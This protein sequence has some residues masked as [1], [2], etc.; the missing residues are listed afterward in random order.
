VPVFVVGVLAACGGTSAPSGAG[1]PIRV[2]GGQFFEGALPTGSAGPAIT[3]LN[4]QN[5]AVPQGEEEKKLGGDAK[6]GAYSV[7]V[8]FEDLGTGYWVVPVGPEDPQTDGDLT[9]DTSSDFARDIQLGKHT[10]G[11]VAADQD[12]NWGPIF[13][14][15]IVITPSVPDGKVVLSLTWDADVD[16]DLHLIAPDGKELDPKHVTTS[17]DPDAGLDPTSGGA[18][19]G[20]LDRDSNGACSIDGRRQEDIVFATAPAPGHY[21]VRVDMFSACGLPSVSFTVNEY[22]PGDAVVDGGT[23]PMALRRKFP[24]RLLDVDADG[25]GPGSGLFVAEL[26]Y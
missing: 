19:V 3:T 7:A 26:V 18:G 21:L 9:W 1:E 15:P 16:L 6:K 17:A 11:F 10:L 23:P 12:G 25:G 13:E 24:G 4:S 2:H 20:I 5:N 8:R 14:L 22:V